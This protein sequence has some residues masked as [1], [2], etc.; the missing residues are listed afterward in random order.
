[1]RR[2]AALLVLL[3]AACSTPRPAILHGPSQPL[4]A[5][6]YT[7]V[8]ETWTRSAKIYGGLETK[9]FMNATFHAPELRRAFAI[10]FPEIYGHGGNVTR[11]E[12]VDLTGDVEQY[13]NLVIA[14]YTPET[15]WNDLAK[16]DSIWRLTLIG[17]D[18]V[19]VGPSEIVPVKVDANLRAVYPYIGRFDKLYLVRFPL[20]DPMG[21]MVLNNDSTSIRL[22]VASALGVAEMVWRLTVPAGG[23]EMAPPEAGP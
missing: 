13:N 5:E 6:D 16:V 20:A 1:M 15:K 23:V 12:L 4:A 11:R 10:A 8:L 21:R 19:A 17:S 18:E 9:A 3:A 2:L 14:L 7:A 22:R